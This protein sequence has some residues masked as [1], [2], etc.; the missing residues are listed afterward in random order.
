MT[1]ELSGFY[2]LGLKARRAEIAEIAALSEE[3]LL[4]LSGELGLSDVHADRMVENALGV[5]GVPLGVCVNLTI[6]G[7]D[8]LVPMAIEEPSVVAASSH[9]AKLMRSGGGIV[10]EVSPPHMIGQVQILEVPDHDEA[11]HRI[12]EAKAELIALANSHHKSLVAAGGGAFDL[13]VRRLDP[14]GPSDPLGPM[15]VVHL[16]ADVRDAMGANAINTMCERLAPRLADLSSG[17]VG[18]R[19]LSNLNDRRT[20]KVEGSVLFSALEKKGAES[21]EL[22]ARQ[23]EEA[24]VFAERDPYRAA[25]HNKGIM[26]G[27]DA[28]LLAFGQDWRAVEAGAHAFAARSGRYTAMARWRVEG[29]R[30]VGRM[31]IPMA[32]GT[33]G[34]V[35]KVH[36]AVRIVRKVACIENAGQ[37]ARIAASVGLI[38]NLGALRALAAEGIQSGHMRLHARNVA[39]EAGA[40][41]DEVGEVARIIADLKQINL[42]AARSALSQV[43]G[44][45]L[46]PKPLGDVMDRFSRL[47]AEH[48]PSIM[49][50]I[51]TVVRGANPDGS[52]LGGMLD[53]HLD[54]GGKR[55]RALT[56]LLV[57]EAFGRSPTEVLALGATCEM[58]H[59]ATLVHDDLQDG[60]T[61]RRGRATVWAHYGMPQAVNL[62]DAMFYYT[63]LLSQRLEIPAVRREA[64]ARRVLV[65]TLRVIDGQEREFAL[66]NA[67][68]ISMTDYFR[69]VEGKTSG[70]FALPMAGAAEVLGMP[71]EVVDGLAEA[72]GHLGVVFQIQD[73]VLDLYGDKGREMRGSDV[74]E[75]KRSAL[76]VHALEHA[77]ERDRAWLIAILDKPREATTEQ[78]VRDV[79]ALFERTGSLDFALDEIQRRREAA[80]SIPALGEHPRV[81]QMVGGLCDLFLQPIAPLYRSKDE[82]LAELSVDPEDLELC[83]RLLPEVSRTFALSIHALPD[84]LRNAVAIAYLLCRIVDTIEDEARIDP[85]DR[86]K[87]FDQFDRTMNADTVDPGELERMSTALELGLLDAEKELMARAGAVFR[88]FRRLD[89]H[90]RDAIRPHV[91]EMSLGMREYTARADAAGKL[92]LR[93]LDD[94][95]RYCYFV[96]GTVGNLLTALFEHMVPVL[97]ESVRT[98]IRERAVSFGLGLQMVNIVKDVAVDF[99][100]GDVFLPEAT[101]REMGVDL[102]DLLAPQKRQE[103]LRV[104]RAVCARARKHLEKAAEYTRLWPVPQGTAIRQFCAVP[105]ALALASL[106]EVENGRDTLRP[107]R[108]PKNHSRAGDGALPG[109]H[110]GRRRRSRAPLAVRALH[111]RARGGR[112]DRGARPRATALPAPGG[113]GGGGARGRAR[114]LAPLR[115]QDAGDRRVLAPGR[116]PDPQAPRRAARGPR[117]LAPRR[118]H[119]RDRRSRRRARAGGSGQGARRRGDHLLCARGRRRGAEPAGGRRAQPRRPRGGGRPARR[120]RH[121]GDRAR[122]PQSGG[123]RAR[124]RARARAAHV[125]PPRLRAVARGPNAPRLRARPALGLDPGPSAPRG[126]R[127]HLRGDDAGDAP[128]PPRAQLYVR[129]RAGRHRADHAS[130]R[131][132][133]GPT[134]PAPADAV[135]TCG[136]ALAPCADPAPRAESHHAERARRA[137]AARMAADLDPKGDPRGLRRLRPT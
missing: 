104:V 102:R 63:I 53:Y 98:A 133:L 25:T 129:H 8:V 119:A 118:E 20:V 117:P 17:R 95:E 116:E 99:E 77:S 4:V 34:G 76:V 16:V 72:A 27:V 21:G 115:G 55:L 111:Q 107:G 32:V 90:Q 84:S 66:K 1:S 10:T 2:R 78:D 56:P 33:V 75:G 12:L 128:R 97:E 121:A 37:L 48:L 7:T 5:L 100:R 60:D 41:G 68:R 134:A 49:T 45:S 14:M 92:V 127:G 62:G 124:H 96:A 120:S 26:N 94:L 86:V 113:R 103:A 91:L 54:T 31:E 44:G 74:G 28:V 136:R 132:G 29:D 61:T 51:E 71:K 79:M 106:V 101:A 130:V 109:G 67:E 108:V 24:S 13:E 52:T 9:A 36:P 73:D 110:R 70:L 114:D 3:E 50:L 87:L 43:R 105:L 137:G 6:D 39:V 65:D 123:G 11:S 64:I 18:L 81:L 40:D 46:E 59:N 125:R 42:E 88:S 58:L 89:K 47:Q 85:Q 126:G 69:M 93:D 19:I 23:I 22:L 57:A 122:V 38:Q 15:L 35:A 135:G 82:V 83:H 30:L 112:R 131:G 80:L